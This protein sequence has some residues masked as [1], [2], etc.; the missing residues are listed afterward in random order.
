MANI[1]KQ[2]RYNPSVG[3]P[4][5][6]QYKKKYRKRYQ[7]KK[8]GV[9]KVYKYKK[10]AKKAKYSAQTVSRTG[11]SAT[12]LN[13][14]KVLYDPW[15]V[16]GSGVGVPSL[17]NAPSQKIKVEARGKFYTSTQGHAFVLINPYHYANHLD[18]S[19]VGANNGDWMSP[20]KFSGSSAGAGCNGSYL[21]SQLIALF[22]SGS[23]DADIAAFGYDIQHAYPDSDMSDVEMIEAAGGRFDKRNWRL[24]GA[25]FKFKYTGKLDER[26]GTY[27]LFKDE[28]NQGVFLTGQRG[29][30]GDTVIT[31]ALLNKDQNNTSTFA[32]DEN[33][34]AVTWQP[35]VDEDLKYIEQWSV[36]SQGIIGTCAVMAVFVYGGPATQQFEFDYVAHY[37]RI[38]TEVDS[39]TPT[40]GDI[41]GQARV[42]DVAPRRPPQGPP[43]ATCARLT[44]RAVHNVHITDFT[45]GFSDG[46]ISAGTGPRG[47]P[48]DPPPGGQGDIPP[49]VPDMGYGAVVALAGGAALLGAAWLGQ[50]VAQAADIAYGNW[51]NEDGVD[52]MAEDATL[53]LLPLPSAPP[54]TPLHSPGAL[55]GATARTVSA[56]SVGTDVRRGLHQRQADLRTAWNLPPNQNA[57]FLEDQEEVV[58]Q[59]V[60]EFLRAM[61]EEKEDL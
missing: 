5:K 12:A 1:W 24:V 31:E 57:R 11:L 41:V 49:L 30:A 35:R 8:K 6:K 2:F 51:D 43:S 18:S 36:A 45:P 29:A 50:V 3:F 34:H 27:T 37:E 21:N 4:K 44:A 15:S 22:N 40:H 16:P 14:C 10:R 60:A 52:A 17:L 13:Y 46:H 42:L 55:T 54:Q 56:S 32:V 20:I 38:G 48:P 53:P 25:G 26:K 33:I 59:G 28:L 39:L 23:T 58:T 47:Y 19:I 7:K 61:H 9:K